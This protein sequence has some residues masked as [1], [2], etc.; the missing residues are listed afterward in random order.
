MQAH[1]IKLELGHGRSTGFV[2]SAFTLIELITVIAIVAVLASLLL[3]AASGAQSKSRVTQCMSNMRQ[4]GTSLSLY[5]DDNHEYPGSQS[6]GRQFGVD[7]YYV[8]PT[9]LL[10]FAMG[11]R[12]IFSCPAS[13]I[14]NI[15]NPAQNRTLGAKHEDG[16][17]D[18]YGIKDVSTF[19][20]GYNDWGIGQASLD[21]TNATQLGLGGDI[22]G[23]FHKGSIRDSMIVNATDMIAFGDSRVDGSWDASIDPTQEDQWPSNRHRRRSI[24]QFVDGHSEVNGR[25]QIIESSISNPWRKR[26][27]RDNESHTE[28]TWGYNLNVEQIL[29]RQ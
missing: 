13:S 11:N 17:F 3:A 7:N 10:P 5:V 4:L 16:T 29:E 12:R 28:I 6:I 25:L 26:W 22:S 27:N 1:R 15:W 20:I 23:P 18:Q 2:S 19:A 24:L 14:R 9:R 21:N 8:W